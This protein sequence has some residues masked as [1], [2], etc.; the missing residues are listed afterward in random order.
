MQQED[1]TT[2]R[3]RQLLAALGVAVLAA[4]A[5]G[6]LLLA[7]EEQQPDTKEAPQRGVAC[8]SIMRASR[9]VLSPSNRHVVTALRDARRDAAGSLQESGIRF[10]KPERLM[11][12]L[13]PE[14]LRNPL[15]GPALDHVTQ[16]LRSAV[17]ACAELGRT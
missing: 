6:S 2:L 17:A 9:S 15:R 16:V 3:K 14:L 5:A 7:N 4:T 11:L 10:G 12:T 1:S 8:S 13:P